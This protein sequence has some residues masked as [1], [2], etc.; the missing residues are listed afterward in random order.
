MTQQKQ[1]SQTRQ[2]WF[3]AAI[4]F[5]AYF[6]LMASYYVIRPT[7]SSM[8]L[9]DWGWQY[10]PIFYFIIAICTLAATFFYNY[11]VG[12]HSRTKLIRFVFQLVIVSFIS[13]W[14]LY[15]YKIAQ[16]VT[17][18]A[19]YLWICIYILF[20]TTLF[21]SFNHDIH[22]PAQ[23]RKLYPYIMLGAQA[24]VYCG[25]LLTRF[26]LSKLKLENYDLILVSA[27]MLIFVWLLLEFLHRYDPHRETARY[28]EAKKTGSLKDLKKLFSNRYA[29]SI[30]IIVVMGTFAF[31]VCDIQY[32]KLLQQE[33]RIIPTYKTDDFASGRLLAKKISQV[34]NPISRHLNS[35]FSSSLQAHLTTITAKLSKKENLLLKKEICHEL[36]HLLTMTA[37]FQKKHMSLL[38]L[39][40]RERKLI[41]SLKK[42]PLR[43]NRLLLDVFLAKELAR[44][45]SMRDQDSKAQTIFLSDNNRYMS[46][47]NILMLFFIAPFLLRSFGPGWTV[48]IYPLATLATTIAFFYGMNIHLAAKFAIGLSVLNYTLYLV[49]KE[50][51]YVPTDKQTKYKIKA[52]IDT[53]GYRLGDAMGGGVTVLYLIFISSTVIS[54]LG[55]VIFIGALVWI[56]SIIFA[57]KNYHKLIDSQK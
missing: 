30:A 45:R 32:K 41:S 46:L 49:G 29:L 22:S 27:L 6:I 25:S 51:F 35:L 24:G 10:M 19:W 13:F 11:Q 42:Q 21:W 40:Q 23:S 43:L 4:S 44:G 1:D 28:A 16:Q 57:H 36:N 37:L 56:P 34:S 47:L 48:I 14:L 12:I 54:G 5:F 52:L 3:G 20:L 50:S 33:I 8:F 17:T 7:R 26:L 18:V 38:C 2:V 31:T 55:A 39:N 53:F 9:K 15:H